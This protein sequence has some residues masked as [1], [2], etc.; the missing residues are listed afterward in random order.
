MALYALL[1]RLTPHLRNLGLLG[2]VSFS[3][4]RKRGVCLATYLGTGETANEYKF[5]EGVAVPL[6]LQRAV[7]PANPGKSCYGCIRK[8]LFALRVTERIVAATSCDSLTTASI[9]RARAQLIIHHQFRITGPYLP[10]IAFEKATIACDPIPGS[11]P[12]YSAHECCTL[13][14]DRWRYTN[15]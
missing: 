3:G 2:S 1:P 13:R 8:R 15:Q 14:E 4:P 12:G 11:S 7:L 6:H 10:P 9:M 5:V